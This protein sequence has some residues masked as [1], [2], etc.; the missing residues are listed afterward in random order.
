MAE[1]ESPFLRPSPWGKLPQQG[2][3][4]I[5]PLPKAGAALAPPP[6]APRPASRSNI[7]AGS[8]IPTAAPAAPAATR[9]PDPPPVEAPRV[10]PTPLAKDQVTLEEVVVTPFSNLQKPRTKRSAAPW[11]IGGTIAAVTA[12][13]GL[14]VLTGKD[15]G[16]A[17]AAALSPPASTTPPAPEPEPESATVETATATETAPATPAPKIAEARPQPRQARPQRT[18]QVSER[19]STPAPAEP[20]AKP[21]TLNPTPIEPPPAAAPVELKPYAPPP[22]PDPEAP[23]TNQQPGR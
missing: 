2:P 7:L 10:E 23:M 20:A 21:I 13:V 18:P 3:M 11:V 4:R 5:G 12:L 15:A 6:A 8:L 19:R 16:Q 22:P 14:V 9:V 17:P 1:P